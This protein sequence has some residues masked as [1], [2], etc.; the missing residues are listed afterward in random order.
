M[1]FVLPIAVLG[2]WV[3][4]SA[5]EEPIVTPKDGSLCLAWSRCRVRLDHF[6]FDTFV[7]HGDGKEEENSLDE[8]TIAFVLQPDGTVGGLRMFGQE[9]RRS[10]RAS[11]DKLQ[12]DLLARREPIQAR[13][14]K[15]EAEREQLE[16]QLKQL[17]AQARRALRSLEQRR[18]EILRQEE[19]RPGRGDSRAPA[20]G[21]KLDRIL[22]KLEQLER[23]LDRLERGGGSS[24]EEAGWLRGPGRMGRRP[25]PA[26]GPRRSAKT[27]PP[28]RVGFEGGGP[29]GR[30][31]KQRFPEPISSVRT[32]TILVGQGNFHGRTAKRRDHSLRAT[33]KPRL[34]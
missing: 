4:C 7:A 26:P 10:L 30:C 19:T 17:E 23:G 21:D 11:A 28:L 24:R 6:H 16:A 12:E 34:R 20:G 1:R 3:S 8:E 5:A 29:P 2:L 22:E 25:E 33:R 15:L 32:A 18:V 31:F 13:L 14:K 9:L 27:R